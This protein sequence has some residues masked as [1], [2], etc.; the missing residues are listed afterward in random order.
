MPISHNIHPLQNIAG[1]RASGAS[2]HIDDATAL[3]SQDGCSSA[4]RICTTSPPNSLDRIIEFEK[5]VPPAMNARLIELRI[6]AHLKTIEELPQKFAF[7]RA[8]V[9]HARQTN[10][11]HQAVAFSAIR[12]LRFSRSDARLNELFTEVERVP[13][14][15]YL[16]LAKACNSS[17]ISL[18]A[19]T[20]FRPTSGETPTPK[21][22]FEAGVIPLDE[23]LQEK[24]AL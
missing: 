9:S 20:P 6:Y 17:S 4:D 13:D 16:N 10:I 12:S 23:S 24:S 14:D 2:S 19:H 21:S 11:Q 18:E 15:V 8:L 22:L 3:A 5:K 1:R 7:L